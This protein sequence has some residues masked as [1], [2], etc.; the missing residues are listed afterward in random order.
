MM[1]SI[2]IK[3]SY[4]DLDSLRPHEESIEERIHY[5]IGSLS[6]TGI[7]RKPLIADERTGVL[8]DGTH[9]YNALKRMGISTAP[10][11]YVDYLS[12]NEIRVA[13]WIRIYIFKNIEQAMINKIADHFRS[14]S[15]EPLVKI[16]RDSYLI[17]LVGKQPANAYRAISHMEKDKN[18][19]SNLKT[20]L[21]RTNISPRMLEKV[22]LVIIPPYLNKEDVI[23][24]GLA[25]KSFPPKS[26]RHIT[27]LKKI[28]LYT[29]I[30]HLLNR[31]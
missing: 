14:F 27:V 18:I 6:S 8:I 19:I 11:I 25:G 21:F 31:Q 20:I 28:K 12:E 13:R 23:E 29:R 5:V 1:K 30:K 17:E 15:C 22:C 10:V 4:S 9:R 7:L 26:T 24:A 16:L 2:R 3:I